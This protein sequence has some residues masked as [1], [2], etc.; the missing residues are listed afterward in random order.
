MTTAKKIVLSVAFLFLGLSSSQAQ[1]NHAVG[2]GLN[3]MTHK[4]DV[5]N[6][7]DGSY[8]GTIF[9]G[10]VDYFPRYNFVE[11][12]NSAWSVGLPVS[13]GLGR[14]NT[15]YESGILLAGDASLGVYFNNGHKATRDIEKPFGF[16]IGGG[17][18][19]GFTNIFLETENLKLKTYG[20]MVHAGVRI[21][22]S[23]ETAQI[24]L[25]YRKGMEADKFSTYGLKFGMDF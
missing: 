5:T 12:G 2:A 13:F 7:E 22:F 24:G 16:F 14:L 18:S 1:F 17:F 23:S 6:S 3:V 10:G 4:L 19:T 25:F 8:I 21:P 20:P 9:R 15:G 11:S